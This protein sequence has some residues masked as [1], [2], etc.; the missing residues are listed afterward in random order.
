MWEPGKGDGE[1]RADF[2]E[3]ILLFVWAFSCRLEDDISVEGLWEA[4]EHRGLIGNVGFWA[5]GLKGGDTDIQA[6]VGRARA[7]E[8]VVCFVFWYVIDDVKA[9]ARAEV[10]GMLSYE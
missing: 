7:G 10:A 9:I 6:V 2:R 4:E 5:I 3:D 1:E 8:A